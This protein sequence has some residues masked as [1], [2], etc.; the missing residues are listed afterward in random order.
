[1]TNNLPNK[2]IVP[3]VSISSIQ[4]TDG[5]LKTGIFSSI[6]FKPPL[7]AKVVF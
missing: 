4:E 1:M 3:Y 2:T 7:E 6:T 5:A